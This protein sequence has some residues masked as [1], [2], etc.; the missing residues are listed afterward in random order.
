MNKNLSIYLDLIRLLA[1]LTVAIGHVVLFTPHSYLWHF[2]I[3]GHEAVIV[4]FVLSGFVIAYSAETK[5][6]D[7]AS[8]AISRFSRLYSVLLPCLIIS[9]L[10][11]FLCRHLD[12]GLYT[13]RGAEPTSLKT[14]LETAF[15]LNQTWFENPVYFANFPIWS[16]GY[17]F[18]YYVIFGAAF[19]LRG[20]TRAAAVALCCLIAGPKVLLLLPIWLM[21]VGAYRI[22]QRGIQARLGAIIAAL[23]VAALLTYFLLPLD[24]PLKQLSA[25]IVGP[26][27]LEAYHYSR[28]LLADSLLGLIIAAHF[29][30]I[31]GISRFIGFGVAAPLIQSLAGFTFSIY[32]FH[33]PLLYLSDAVL[34][35]DLDGN[36]RATLIIIIAVGGSCL[37][38][39]FTER[40]KH[41]YAQMLRALQLRLFPAAKPV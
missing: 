35:R 34:P 23:S 6:R 33:F 10:I 5:D 28:F 40:K 24:L 14:I 16:L 21:G 7:L 3:L 4:F 17:E 22:I 2:W 36:W 26:Q 1:A 39:I 25:A 41:L 31:A 37:L 20:W 13:G 30:G 29:I 8:Y 18:W 12:P 27:N 38:G 15:F 9:P 11:Y 32:L 19:F